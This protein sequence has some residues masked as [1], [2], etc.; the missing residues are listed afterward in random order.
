MSLFLFHFLAIGDIC[1]TQA[2]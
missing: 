1:Q 2:L